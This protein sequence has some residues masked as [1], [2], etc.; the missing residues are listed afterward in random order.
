MNLYIKIEV[1][2]RNQR[3]RIKEITQTYSLKIKTIKISITEN[4]TT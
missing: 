1:K 3:A 4:S 2:N